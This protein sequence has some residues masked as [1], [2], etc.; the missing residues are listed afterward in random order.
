MLKIF[1]QKNR[2]DH[3]TKQV[4]IQYYFLLKGQFYQNVCQIGRQRTGSG[5]IF[6]SASVAVI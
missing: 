6:F 2:A 1:M 4:N 5:L 3:F